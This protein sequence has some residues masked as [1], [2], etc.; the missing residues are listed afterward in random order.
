ML[1]SIRI[2]HKRHPSTLSV[3]CSLNREAV[4]FSLTIIVYCEV[5]KTKTQTSAFSD[6]G[7]QSAH[8]V[9]PHLRIVN[10]VIRQHGERTFSWHETILFSQH[11]VA[12]QGTFTLSHPISSR[13]TICLCVTWGNTGSPDCYNNKKS[14][15]QFFFSNLPS[16]PAVKS[17]Q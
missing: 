5:T 2:T 15:K 6:K 1:D 16:N 12:L 11:D 13:S 10:K 4:C 9:I 7:L 3:N 14:L 8:S 17:Q